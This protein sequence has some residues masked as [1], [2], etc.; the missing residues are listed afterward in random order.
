M[1]IANPENNY[2]DANTIEAKEGDYL[3]TKASQ[4]Q[5]AGNGL[6]TAIAIYK[7][8][9]ITLFKGEILDTKEAEK[10][11]KQNN[12]RYFINLLDGTIMDSMHTDC[13]AKYANDA[14]NSNFKKNAEITLD[15]DDNVCLKAIK[16]IKSGEEIF[17]SYG[18]RYWKKHH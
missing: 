12:D 9:I 11:A 15:A 16:K 2:I 14:I 13:F 17:C 3:Y 6:Y 8:E 5:N 1:K 10:R 7:N 4:I 18:K